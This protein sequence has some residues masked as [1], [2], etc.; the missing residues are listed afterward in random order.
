MLIVAI[1]ATISKMIIIASSDGYVFGKLGCAKI[2]PQKR[3]YARPGRLIFSMGSIVI[4]NDDFLKI[5]CLGAF[6]LYN[7]SI[8]TKDEDGKDY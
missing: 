1:L 2:I 6:L 3:H 4:Y 8:A 7:L 5:L